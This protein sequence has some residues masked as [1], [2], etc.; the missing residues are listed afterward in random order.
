MRDKLITMLADTLNITRHGHYSYMGTTV[1]LP[2]TPERRMEC[3]VLL[4]E[5]VH[6]LP[7]VE[8]TVSGTPCEYSVVNEDTFSAA[9]DWVR[10]GYDKVLALNLAN[11]VSPGGGVT[12]GAVA[13]EE[14]LCRRSTLLPVL[15]SDAARPYYV[16]NRRPTTKMGSDGVILTPYVDV[17]REPDGHKMEKPFTTGV[18]TAAAP[19]VSYGYEGMSEAQYEELFE[20]R[21]ESLLKACAYFGYKN[22]VLGAWGCGAFGND[23]KVVA[24]LFRKVIDNMVYSGHTCSEL[25]EHITFAVLCVHRTYNYEMFCREFKGEGR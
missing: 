18:I 7:D 24:R 19:M 16:Y 2:S 3:T 17:F 8:V 5:E 23:A 1:D 21:I 13:Q 12:R 20:K 6:S 22:L 10:K 15:D 9:E 11:P 4:P 25:F 14:D